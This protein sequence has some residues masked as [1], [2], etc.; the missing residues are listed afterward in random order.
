MAADSS[1]GWNNRDKEGIEKEL[2][3]PPAKCTYA[4]SGISINWGDWGE[5]VPA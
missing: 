3:N 4:T 5:P 2:R 1:S